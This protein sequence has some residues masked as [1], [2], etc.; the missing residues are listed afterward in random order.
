MATEPRI[1]LRGVDVE[2]SVD[3]EK[4][5]SLKSAAAGLL[6]PRRTV[7]R[8]IRA[9]RG[10]SLDIR[11]GERVGLVGPNGAGKSTLLKVMARIYPPVRGEVEV[12]GRVCPLFEFVTGFEMECSGRDNIRTRTLLLGMSPREVERKLEEIGEFTGLG[13]F[14]D[15]PVRCYSSGMLLRLAFAASTAVEP[16]ILLL[17]EVMAAG[18]AEFIERA[19]A[20]I[21]GVM[22]RASIVVFASHS[23]TTLPE[24]CERTIWIDR[25]RVAADGPTREVVRAYE[26]SVG[27]GAGH[28]A[29]VA[30]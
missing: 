6:R 30:G 20:R 14:L 1:T 22:E 18:D 16:E 5:R 15:F 8:T 3:A 19:R 13:E 21:N 7:P 10:V 12:G 29:A 17:D 26:A 11:A 28:A 27:K 23:L 24:F 25:G 9:L 2:F 4:H